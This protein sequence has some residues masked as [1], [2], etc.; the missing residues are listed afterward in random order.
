MAPVTDHDRELA[1]QLPD[2]IVRMPG[3][4]AFERVVEL[5]NHCGVP[6]EK[7][8]GVTWPVCCCLR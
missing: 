7:C 4:N 1:W 3:E 5:V 2:E 6:T 8:H